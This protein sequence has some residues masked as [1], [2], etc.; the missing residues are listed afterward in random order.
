M[1][2]TPE[3]KRAKQREKGEDLKAPPEMAFPCVRFA[4]QMPS[5]EGVEEVEE[6]EKPIEEGKFSA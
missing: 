1:A 2:K 6:P 3:E 4:G 5:E